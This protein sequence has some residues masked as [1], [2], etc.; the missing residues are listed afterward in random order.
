MDIVREFV[1]PVLELGL[2]SAGNGLFRALALFGAELV[3][4]CSAAA[5]RVDAAAALRARGGA[6]AVRKLSRLLAAAAPRLPSPR[7]P[8]HVD[9]MGGSKRVHGKG[10]GARASLRH[11]RKHKLPFRSVLLS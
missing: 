1:E 6:A 11:V 8:P 4:Q 5:D 9:V 3:A 7:N 2:G 10:F